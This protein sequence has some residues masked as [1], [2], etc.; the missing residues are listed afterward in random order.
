MY[1][2]STFVALLTPREVHVATTWVFANPVSVFH[3]ARLLDTGVIVELVTSIDARML[4][5]FL[6][7]TAADTGISHQRQEGKMTH[8]LYRRH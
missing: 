6:Q 8:S 3:R 2:P 5:K 7:R 1:Q 4:P